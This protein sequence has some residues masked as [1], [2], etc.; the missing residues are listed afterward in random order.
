LVRFIRG[1][2]ESGQIRIVRDQ[3]TEAAQHFDRSRPSVVYL[4]DRRWRLDDAIVDDV[5]V[6][7]DD[8]A[9]GALLRC[10]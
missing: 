1:S 3:P 9:H 8:D 7:L 10:P 2:I 4:I 5:V 6:L